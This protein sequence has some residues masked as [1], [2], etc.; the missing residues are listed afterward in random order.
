MKK[1]LL[2]IIIPVYGKSLSLVE[3]L[4]NYLNSFSIQKD[5]R[6]ILVYKNSNLFNYDALR[7]YDSK[8]IRIFQVSEDSKR[9]KKIIKGINESNSEYILFLDAHHSI[10]FI[11]ISKFLDELKNTKADI[12]FTSVY[13]VNVDVK[14]SCKSTVFATT[15]GR[16]LLKSSLIKSITNKVDFDVI[17]HDDWSMGLLVLFNYQILDIIWME[18]PF[19]LKNYG[20]ELSNTKNKIDPSS[21]LKKFEDSLVILNYFGKRI[22]LNRVY[23]PNFWVMFYRLYLENIRNYMNAHEVVFSTMLKT[24]L[25]YLAVD[26]FETDVSSKLV[27]FKKIFDDNLNLVGNSRFLMDNDNYLFLLKEVLKNEK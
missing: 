7:K 18:N 12:I 23:N 16:Y 19:Y 13:E 15:A 11:K 25:K 17:F 1:V 27:I 5:I 6:F 26:I 22:E 14:K 9:T 4:I 2:E 21:S 8:Y 24:K 10:D 3:N 20:E